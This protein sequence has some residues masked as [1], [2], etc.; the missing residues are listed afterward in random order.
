MKQTTIYNALKALNARGWGFLRRS[1]WSD[2]ADLHYASALWPALEDYA[3]VI[4]AALKANEV[5]VYPVHTHT[6]AVPGTAPAAAAAA[7]VVKTNSRTSARALAEAIEQELK[8]LEGI[9]NVSGFDKP[10]RRR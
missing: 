9:F 6:K 7:M 3:A 4:R 2:N 8:A 1:E 5:H 10:V